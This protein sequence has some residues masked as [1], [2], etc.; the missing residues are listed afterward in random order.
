MLGYAAV[1]AAVNL[2]MD[3]CE[4]LLPDY[5]SF[6]KG[7]ADSADLSLNISREVLQH[8]Y[9]LKAIAKNLEKKIELADAEP[10]KN[11]KEAENDCQQKNL[12]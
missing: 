10:H 8:D 12:L 1:G 5:F 4:D 11:V 2:I 3:K 7:L 6:V 9:V